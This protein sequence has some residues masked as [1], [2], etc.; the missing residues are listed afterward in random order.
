MNDHADTDRDQAADAD[1]DLVTILETSDALRIDLA[2]GLLE[3]A[4]I[5]YLAR[6]E[7]IQDLFGLGRL[8]AVNPISGPVCIQVVRADAER[9]LRI[10]TDAMDRPA[11][12]AEPL[13]D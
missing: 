2:E 12:E 8:T 1:L 13:D 5:P 7:M 4:G 3:S 6:G 11:D 9:A 10:L